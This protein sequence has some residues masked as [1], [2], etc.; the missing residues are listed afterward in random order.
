[1]LKNKVKKLQKTNQSM[2]M[3]FNTSNK[4]NKKKL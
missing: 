1:M 2:L 3:Q 4:T